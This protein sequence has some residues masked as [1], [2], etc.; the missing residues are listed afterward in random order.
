MH[1]NFRG[2]SSYGLRALGMTLL[3]MLQYN[4][5]IILFVGSMFIVIKISVNTTFTMFSV[6]AKII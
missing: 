1:F 6:F 2:T 5:N 4:Y 3:F